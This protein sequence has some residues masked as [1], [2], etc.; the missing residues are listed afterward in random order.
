MTVQED[1]FIKY[2]LEATGWSKVND[3]TINY[4][5]VPK[6]KVTE[7]GAME[8]PNSIGM[9]KP[10]AEP[11]TSQKKNKSISGAYN[12]DGLTIY[13]GN[14]W[15]P[16]AINYACDDRNE[17]VC[18]K[19]IRMG[20]LGTPATT[21]PITTTK[22]KNE[23]FLIVDFKDTTGTENSFRIITTHLESGEEGGTKRTTTMDVISDVASGLD[24]EMQTYLLMDGNCDP[25]KEP[26]ADQLKKISDE[27]CH[28]WEGVKKPITT[29]KDRGPGTDQL[30]KADPISEQIDWAVY[31]GTDTTPFNDTFFIPKTSGNIATY[32]IPSSKTEFVIPVPDDRGDIASWGHW[33][34]DH[35]P[36]IFKGIYDIQF[37][38][39]NCL[40]MGLADDGFFMGS[41]WTTN[42]A[43]GGKRGRVSRRCTTEGRMGKKRTRRRSKGR[44]RRS[45]RRSKGRSQ[46]R[47]KGRS[48]RMRRSNRRT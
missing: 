8:L 32:A 43:G 39:L 10:Y 5:H 14:N 30:W 26:M 21:N 31:L 34:S 19:S 11:F 44:T 36:I 38:Q 35:F 25:N 6:T 13:Y 28:R 47:T 4:I 42:R 48:R 37:T 17:I 12:G 40:A 2:Q 7:D 27:T 15:Q 24:T 23:L 9:G 1:D 41:E 16:T 3:D 46:R 45:Q 18:D 22:Y 29:L 33:S 20:K